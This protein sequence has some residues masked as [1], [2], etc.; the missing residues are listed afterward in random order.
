MK[1]LL[2][3]KEDK[4]MKTKIFVL[5]TCIIW[6]SSCLVCHPLKKPV[7]LNPIDVE[8]YNDGYTVFWNCKQQ[9]MDEPTPYEGDTIKVYG[10]GKGGWSFLLYEDSTFK[11]E[12][13]YSWYAIEIRN[14]FEIPNFPEGKG[15]YYIKGI[16]NN[17]CQTSSHCDL[18]I[19]MLE[20][21]FIKNERFKQRA[22]R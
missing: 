10:W 20:Y 8:N 21:I 2:I 22:Q 12:I 11:K 18:S 6:L 4:T 19:D 13:G 3:I 5:S 7:D 17:H 14:K 9:C 15:M 16:V 1:R